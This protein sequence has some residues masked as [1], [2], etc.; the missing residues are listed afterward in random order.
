MYSTIIKSTT[1]KNGVRRLTRQV[2]SDKGEF[3]DPME[4]MDSV[5]A[6]GSYMEK[7]WSEVKEQIQL[8]VD[9]AKND[10]FEEG[11]DAGFSKL[12]DQVKD[13]MNEFKE[14]L[15]AFK[16]DTQRFVEETEKFVLRISIKIAEKILQKKLAEEDD[17]TVT[18]VK[19]AL[20][21]VQDS[22]NLVIRVNPDD[23]E[24]IKGMDSQLSSNGSNV[25]ISGDDGIERGGCKIESDW[26]LVDARIDTQLEKIY[27][28][29][30]ITNNKELASADDSDTG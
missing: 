16:A 5:I 12:K 9:S 8:V 10:G 4:E 13:E 25:V 17:F 29:L 7:L 23:Y 19:N 3:T 28:E 27:S 11:R 14:I 18:I 2:R 20:K 30:V 21:T 1:T 22:T 26:G 15:V 6:E 24:F